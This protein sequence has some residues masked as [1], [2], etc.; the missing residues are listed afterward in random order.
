MKQVNSYYCSITYQRKKNPTS[1]RQTNGVSANFALA[2]CIPTRNKRPEPVRER[3]RQLLTKL[4]TSTP[5][6]SEHLRKLTNDKDRPMCIEREDYPIS[7]L[8]NF[9]YKKS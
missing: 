1:K 4:E 3:D 7:P 6:T 5:K 8:V 9:M 2:P